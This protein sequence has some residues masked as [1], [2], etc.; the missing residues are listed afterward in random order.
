MKF[1]KSDVIKKWRKAE[2]NFSE[3]ISS[4]DEVEKVEDVS[5]KNFG[6]DVL[7]VLKN[8]ENRYYEVKS[9]DRLGESFC[10]TNNEVTTAAQFGEEY[11]LAII[12]QSATEFAMCFIQNPFKNLDLIKRVTRWEWLCNQYEG[13]V[14][15]INID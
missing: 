7:A 13:V 2:I 6:Y 3:V 5:E 10:L 12:S 11:F 4:F 15:K 14:Y 1:I 9:V 8:G